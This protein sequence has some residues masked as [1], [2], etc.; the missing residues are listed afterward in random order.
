MKRFIPNLMCLML[1]LV[2]GADFSSAQ[3]RKQPG[4]TPQNKRC[5]TEESLERRYRTDPV[6][7]AMM[8]QRERDFLQWQAQRNAGGDNTTPNNT[9][10]L[11][12]PVIIPV[13]VHVVLPNPNVIQESDVDY[14]INR[15]NLDFSGLNPDSTNGVNFYGVRG[16][17][18]IRFCLAK[19]DPSGNFTNGIERR[20]GAGTIGGGE[21]QAIKN[22]AT[23]GLSP[24]PTNLYYNIYVGVGGG[25]LGIAPEIGPGTAASDGVCLDFQAFSNG[26]YSIPQ[27]NLG[28]TASHEVGHNFGLYH[29]FSGAC[30]GNDM[31]Q[32][33][34][35]GCSLPGSILG[36]PDDTP[37]QSASTSGC[38]TGN[39]ASGC[40]VSPN[41][42]GKMYQNYMD[43]T[44]DACYS[45]FT[46][47]Q[48]ARMEWVLEN[49][50]AGYLTSN[51]CQLPAG[52]PAL[53][54]AAIE[55]INP[56]GSE[57]ITSPCS[58]LSYTASGCSPTIAPKLRIQNRGTTTITSITV[59]VTLN[60]VPQAAQTIAVNI[61]Y[62]KSQ[63]VTLNNITQINGA[64]SVAFAISAPN[65]GV[66]AVAGNNTI[67]GNATYTPPATIP[68][69]LSQDFVATTY[70][71]ANLT[72]VNPNN[73][74]TWVRSNAGNIN[75]GSSF[76]DFY[77]N[78]AQGQI[79]EIRT[80]LLDIGTPTD[81]VILQ[82]DLAHKNFP[83]AGFYDR[84]VV[85]ISSDCGA[86][87]TTTGTNP[88]FD[89][90]GPV[91]A[92]AGSSTAG[93]LNP[94][95]A[96]WRTQ[97]IAIFTGPTSPFASSGKIMVTFRGINGYGNNVFID[98]IN[99]FKKV[100]RDMLV[101]LVNRPSAEECSP[102]FT[103][104]VV[105]RNNG[106]ETITQYKVGYRV[107][108][109]PPVALIT[110][111]TAIAPGATAVITLA[112]ATTGTGNHTFC[113]FTADPVSS[114]GSGDQS[115]GNDTLCTSFRVRQLYVNLNENFE[116]TA[117]PSPEWALNNPNAN[118]T[119]LRR[120]PG[121]NSIRS[122]FID[123]YNNNLP[124]QI[125]ELISP[126]VYCLNADSVTFSFDV[127]HK[128][129]P[130][131]DDILSV[132]TSSNCGITYA[133]TS[134]A[135]GGA[136]LA[137][138][139]SSTANYTSP[140]DGDWRRDRVTV[141]GAALSAGSL[142]FALRNANAYGNNIF[143]D[144]INITV[145]FKRDIAVT[146]VI[147]PVNEC[148]Q[149]VGPSVRITN[150]GQDTVKSFSVSYVIDGVLPAQTANFTGLNLAA[151]QSMTAT[152]PTSSNVALGPHNL[153]V[154]STNLVAT[155]GAGDF[156]PLNDSMRVP[157][158]VLG[159]Q[160]APLV[161][162]FESGTVPPAKW[163]INNPDLGLTWTRQNTGSNSSG[164][165][166]VQ[167]YIYSGA[168]SVS[169][170]DNL[171]TPVVTYS[172]VDSVYL[173]F[174][175]SAAT[176]RYP[177]STQIP[178]DTLEV[179]VT[180]DC[181]T[182]F[183]TVWKKWGEDLQTID[184]PNAPNVLAYTPNNRDWKMVKLNITQFAG[185]SA[186]NLY[187]M[188]RNG[189]NNDNNVYID[190]VNLSTLTLPAKLKQQGYLLY[191]SPFAG[192]FN[193]Q[194]YLPPTDL[195]YIE[196]FNAR[197]Q[198]VY[199]KAFGSNGANSTEKIDLSGV[200]AGVYTVKLGYTNKQVVERLVKTSN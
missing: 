78:T 190:N 117:F 47:T 113:A 124:G 178:I 131:F 118:V 36:L 130:G 81:S 143:I 3:T 6:Y 20:S 156:Y 169:Q 38:P 55:I 138:A 150:T 154:Y 101:S 5:A 62:G 193:V 189:S 126:P 42:P 175:V 158:N 15:L 25:L 32:L 153:L 148:S 164:S 196:V 163:A 147:R 80:R 110:I 53:D 70:P 4:N 89:R 159:T 71:P 176:R 39:A 64:N 88:V 46:K 146:S 114:S 184:D 134:Y 74:V 86:T 149:N 136:A 26:C 162:G 155:S 160:P 96:D 17:S 77:N 40:A 191:P 97:R 51:G 56:G 24:W 33:T 185:T 22:F 199:R 112:P 140:A 63:V 18:Q 99:I 197:G 157:F 122:M 125:D 120:T 168:Q 132:R 65:G 10:A 167:N 8:D 171:V 116:G 137:T 21:P 188:F 87:F 28:R 142:V 145:Y 37:A 45:M 11:T 111:N 179:I 85:L 121:R 186:S 109:N 107:D 27:F 41:P 133:P 54:A 141:S 98:N 100:G 119:W 129:F 195:R 139:G 69:P 29:T 31:G 115:V 187:V 105:V 200:A 84:M 1:L 93:Y 108:N 49:C 30:A 161:E 180:K 183:T 34:S 151:G 177:G 198:M 19:R 194:H 60:G 123:N 128:N 58:I 170:S 50:R 104:Q 182:T 94:L 75:V 76:I 79:D 172:S 127:A 72:I 68:M 23:G 12:G 106:Q 16:H 166:S 95:A 181:G 48:V 152:L 165:A 92:T 43:Y 9:D 91:L 59:Q 67:S 57:L 173:A 61:P 52:L 82:F 102:T 44:D 14:L 103:P 35:A 135:R 66:D 83:N 192:S 174:D 2:L 90:T 73:N 144:N 13:V 7:R